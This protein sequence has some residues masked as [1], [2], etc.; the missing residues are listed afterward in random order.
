MKDYSK[1]VVYKIVS[2]DD[3]I[4]DMYIGSTCSFTSRKYAHKKA[5]T[6]RVGKTYRRKVYQFIRDNGGFDNFQIIIIE[7][8]PCN[9]RL[10]LV[11]RERHWYNILKPS[12]NVYMP[13]RTHKEYMSQP[14][15]KAR[16]KIIM[17]K[18]YEDNLESQKKKMRD[19]SLR[20]LTC[21]ICQHTH[22]RANKTNHY[23]KKYH[24]RYQMLADENK[25][26]NEKA[27]KFDQDEDEI[28][29]EFNKI[30][31]LIDSVK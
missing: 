20:V 19:Y 31:S 5:T 2:K 14:H 21:D 13:N 8:Y 24:I 29:K 17:K 15:V 26:L 3:N 7:S 25:R 9:T 23:Q 18:Y 6:N 27:L 22:S 12:L 1:G 4:S 28:M 11:A 30:C 10:E 16:N